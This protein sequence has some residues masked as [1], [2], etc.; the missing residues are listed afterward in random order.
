[1]GAEI[2]LRRGQRL[3]WMLVNRM[4]GSRASELH[5]DLYTTCWRQV[6]DCIRTMPKQKHHVGGTVNTQPWNTTKSRAHLCLHQCLHKLQ[7]VLYSWTGHLKRP[8]LI[9]HKTNITTWKKQNGFN[10]SFCNFRL[11]ATCCKS[12][13]IIDPL[14]LCRR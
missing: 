10:A 1:M 7:I 2:L 12:N 3:G 8:S 14:Y 11:A 9:I 4:S 5:E 13:V 6:P